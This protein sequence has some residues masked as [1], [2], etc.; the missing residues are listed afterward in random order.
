MDYKWHHLSFWDVFLLVLLLFHPVRVRREYNHSLKVL[1][2]LLSLI[3]EN[4]AIGTR[5]PRVLGSACRIAQIRECSHMVTYVK[6]ALLGIV[7]CTTCATVGVV[8]WNN[9]SLAFASKSLLC[10]SSSVCM[11]LICVSDLPSLQF[12]GYL[13][14]WRTLIFFSY[15]DSSLLV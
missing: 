5:G 15:S 11:C 9:I 3:A 10:L 1:K 4:L 2:V 6:M 7:Q 14:V 12:F 13:C 8:L